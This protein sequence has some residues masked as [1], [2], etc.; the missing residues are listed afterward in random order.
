MKN[1]LLFAFLF[2]VGVFFS[3]CKD[4]G[5]EMAPVVNFTAPADNSTVSAGDTV[6][7]SFTVT[8]D[9][10]L[11]TINLS[12]DLGLNEDYTTFDSEASHTEEFNLIINAST[13]AGAYS[14]TVTGTDS[15]DNEGQGVV[16]VT[17]Q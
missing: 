3:S 17:I 5:D 8:D 7:V 9:E 1:L 4:D 16:N 15:S 6:F 13:P 10:S 11:K 2:T 12:S 14:M